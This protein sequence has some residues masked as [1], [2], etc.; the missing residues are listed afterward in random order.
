MTRKAKSDSGSSTWTPADLGENPSRPGRED[1]QSPVAW[2]FAGVEWRGVAQ[3]GSTP[4]RPW[5]F[6]QQPDSRL[7][8]GREGTSKRPRVVRLLWNERMRAL[9]PAR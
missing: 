5:S 7:S 8:D 2:G 3:R 9:D 6:L 4:P 1:C